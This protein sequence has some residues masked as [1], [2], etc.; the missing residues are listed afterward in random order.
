MLVPKKNPADG[1]KK[2]RVLCEDC[3]GDGF[4]RVA[5]PAA[6][7]IVALEEKLLG[8]VL[9]DVNSDL[10]NKHT[11]RLNDVTRFD[12]YEDAER[13]EKTEVKLPGIITEVIP[14]KTGPQA[15]TP[16]ADFVEVKIQWGGAECKFVAWPEQF[17][18]F[19]YMLKP[20]VLGEFTLITG[21]K[22]P[23]LKKGSRIVE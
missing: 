2:A 15:W 10:V 9:T 11:E 3:N 8:I 1:M 19:K 6:D 20:R 4:V 5:L 17:E 18:E 13:E 23:K 16:N 14:K 7:E 21:K 12:F 22:G